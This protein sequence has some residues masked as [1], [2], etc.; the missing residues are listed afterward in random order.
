[1]G[2]RL[3]NPHLKSILWID[4][5][6]EYRSPTMKHLLYSLPYL[7][8][9]GWT[10]K[11]WCLRSDIPPSQ[12]EQVRLPYPFELGPFENLYFSIIVNLLWLIRL[13]FRIPPPASIIHATGGT[14]MGANLITLQ[15]LHTRWISIQ[16]RIGFSSVEEMLRF[17]LSLSDLAL[18][19]LQLKS[20]CLQRISTVS[21]AISRL[22][23]KVANRNLP[24]DT[25]P[26]S[27]DETRF[28]TSVRALYRAPMRDNL[29]LSERDIA[30]IFVSQGHFRRK[31]LWLAIRALQKLRLDGNR[32]LKLLIVGGNSRA[33]RQ[34]RSQLCKE[35]SDWEDWILLLGMQKNP[36]HFYAAADAFLFPSFFEAFCL[37]E[38][39]AA[40]CGL[41]LLLTRHPGSEMILKNGK[42]GTFLSFNVNIMSQQIDSFL[43]RGVKTFEA[44]IGR[45][46]T[47]DQYASRLE[48]IYTDHLAFLNKE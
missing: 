35:V 43:A 30:F 21:T 8:K 17:L 18:E 19:R 4:P 10:I 44:S 48:K 15:F 33:I 11:A 22:T 46:M 13:L 28:N 38:I 9:Q 1:M 34:L 47:R 41:P 36:E 32:R 26:N 27:Y 39:E 45:A 2:I 24:I 40:A 42:N 5:H 23:K 3:T 6:L 7:K 25:L 31:G 37:A 14:C 29:K 16:H 12:V 20:N